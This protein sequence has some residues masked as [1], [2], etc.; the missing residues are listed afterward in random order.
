MRNLKP[1]GR[2]IWKSHDTRF[3][4]IFPMKKVMFGFICFLYSGQTKVVFQL[5][6]NG[7]LNFVVFSACPVKFPVSSSVRF[8]VNVE[9]IWKALFSLLKALLEIP[10]ITVTRCGRWTPTWPC[11]AAFKHS[12]FIKE[13]ILI[14]KH[15][16]LLCF[17]QMKTKFKIAT[18]APRNQCCTTSTPEL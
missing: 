16:S 11:F 5:H 9:T 8:K 3:K 12:L 6:Q 10:T 18:W 2:R 14:L 7:G 1:N 4:S 15:F 17:I 13:F